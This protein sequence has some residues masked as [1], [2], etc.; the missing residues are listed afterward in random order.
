MNLFLTMK[1]TIVLFTG[2]DR[3]VGDSM[4]VDEEQEDYVESD[5]R[6]AVPSTESSIK[7]STAAIAQQSSMQECSYHAKADVGEKQEDSRDAVPSTT[8]EESSS[9]TTQSSMQE[10][11]FI[12]SS[13]ETI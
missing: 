1:L 5:S 7:K 6:D 3:V 2:E 8:T 12:L 4:D 11:I 10:Y 9:T 13:Y